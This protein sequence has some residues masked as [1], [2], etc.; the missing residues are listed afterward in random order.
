MSVT[1]TID[2]RKVSV[3]EGTTIWQVARQA[4]IEIPVLC[5]DPRLRPVG[6]CRVCVVDVGERVLAASCVRAAADGMTVST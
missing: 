3:P 5:H 2:G 6:V 4:G 1:L